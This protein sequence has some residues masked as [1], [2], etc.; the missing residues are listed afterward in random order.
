SVA[1]TIILSK[2]DLASAAQIAQ[3]EMEARAHNP[4]ASIQRRS[5]IADA[6]SLI[7]SAGAS[8]VAASCA[9]PVIELHHN[10]SRGLNSVVLRRQAPLDWGR[11]NS[12]FM[13]LAKDNPGIVRL[14]GVV[15]VEGV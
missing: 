4:D 15:Q 8:A 14:K 5:G 3:A 7:L 6:A 13:A 10:H 11:L 9:K 1:D 12:W 2:D